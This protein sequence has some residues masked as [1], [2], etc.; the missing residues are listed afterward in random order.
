MLFSLFKNNMEKKKILSLL[1]DRK[2]FLELRR[3]WKI[4][5]FAIGMSWLFYGALFYDISDWDVG[6]SILMGGFTY[7]FAPWSVATIYGALRLRSVL[8]PV[9]II[10][11][12]VPAM[13]TVDGVYWL[14]HSIV[15]N[16]MMRWENFKVSMALYFICGILWSYDGS[17]REFLADLGIMVAKQK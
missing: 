8:W 6:I 14:Y 5:T 10:V 11:A 15:G 17:V 2:Y 3:P 1:P 9:R 13:F 4:A 7:I 16:S 12:L